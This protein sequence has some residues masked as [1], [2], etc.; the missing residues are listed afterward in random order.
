MN[1]RALKIQA[2]EALGHAHGSSRRIVLIHAVISMGVSLVLTLLSSLLER[3]VSSGGGLRGMDAQ[4]A[5][6]TAQVVLQLAG[7][8]AMPFWNAGLIFAA[9]GWMKGECVTPRNL[10]EGFRRFK[11]VLSSGL[12][13]G[14]Q[15]LT[16]S[17]ISVYLTVMLVMATPFAAPAYRLAVMLEE[18]PQLD[19][20]TVQL[21]GITGLYAAAAIIFVLVFC[22][23]SFPVYYRYRMVN[24]IIMDEEKVGGL[25]AMFQSRLMMRHRIRK[26]VRVDLSFWWYYALELVLSVVSLGAMLAEIFGIPL[27]VGSDAAHW[28]FLLVAAGGHLALRWWAGPKMEVTYALCYREFL[29][30]EEPPAPKPPKAHPWTY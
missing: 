13:I 18:N 14:I 17:I 27:P 22:V 23:L 12:M 10:M 16:R 1:I 7:A 2:Q 6:S 11:P 4:A 8:V 15:Y 30:P 28:V 3:T 5:L 21:D 19:P 26:L 24:Y 9:L 20:S 29:Q 25:R